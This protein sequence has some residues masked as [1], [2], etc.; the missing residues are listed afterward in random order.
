MALNEKLRMA[1]A[2]MVEFDIFENRK[3]RIADYLAM[4]EDELKAAIREFVGKFNAAQEDE[5][6]Q[7]Q[8]Q[9]DKAEERKIKE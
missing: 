9:A 4:S 6:K 2:E 7:K 3:D 5:R 8:Q 1:F